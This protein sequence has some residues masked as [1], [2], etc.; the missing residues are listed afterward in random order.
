[1]SVAGQ[2]QANAHENGCKRVVIHRAASA[3]ILGA[4]GQAFEEVRGDLVAGGRVGHVM[5][6]SCV[7][8]RAIAADMTLMTL[9]YISRV[10]RARARVRARVYGG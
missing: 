3:Y 9:R 7:W 1:V 4:G 2:R 5:F 8:F 6:L 10:L